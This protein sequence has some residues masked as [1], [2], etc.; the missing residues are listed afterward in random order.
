MPIIPHRIKVTDGCEAAVNFRLKEQ[1]PLRVRSKDLVHMIRF[2]PHFLIVNESAASKEG[3]PHSISGQVQLAVP[4]ESRDNLRQLLLRAGEGYFHRPSYVSAETIAKSENLQAGLEGVMRTYVREKGFFHLLE[5]ETVR[6]ELDQRVVELCAG[7]GLK[8]SLISVEASHL[9][10]E[11]AFVAGLRARAEP[12]N[13]SYTNTEL[14]RVVDFFLESARSQEFITEDA[15]KE[16]EEGKTRAKLRAIK[17]Q[18][19]IDREE[20]GK[21]KIDST[22]E[23][24]LA[25]LRA[26]VVKAKEE[27]EKECQEK[28][29]EREM[30]AQKHT[31]ALTELKHEGLVAERAQREKELALEAEHE[32]KL[33]DIR[34]GEIRA[35]MD[36]AKGLPTADYSGVNSLVLTEGS[37]SEALQGLLLKYLEK[38]AQ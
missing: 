27:F 11:P 6:S 22:R 5:Q 16:E 21:T 9:E 37:S 8:A 31:K 19:E 1:R 10:A 23:E 26:N 14:G 36:A 35:I 2:A 32:R 18:M 34:A 33:S 3:V 25:R 24:E 29:H 13:G 12:V 7:V 28:R 15:Q 20:E 4:P 38:F 17:A 30:D